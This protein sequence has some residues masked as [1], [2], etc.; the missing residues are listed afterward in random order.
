MPS[1][2]NGS[3]VIDVREILCISYSCPPTLEPQSILLA[4]LLGPLLESG[5]RSHVLGLEP[6]PVPES[7]DPFL[8]RLVPPDVRIGRIPASDRS[9]WFRVVN[10]YLPG[11]LRIPDQHLPVHFRA[12]RAGRAAHE[13]T[14]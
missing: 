8:A 6:S 12:V 10:R 9:V 13:R 5:Y 7:T 14:P 1:K 11:L 4:K 3:P 2:R